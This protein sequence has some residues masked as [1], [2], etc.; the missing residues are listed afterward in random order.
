MTNEQ[1][2]IVMAALKLGKRMRQLQRLYEKNADHGVFLERSLAE[3]EFDW[4]LDAALGDT[5]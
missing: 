4:A 3:K 2:A 5:K 1:K